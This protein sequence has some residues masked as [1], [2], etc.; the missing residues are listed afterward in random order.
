IKFISHLVDNKHAFERALTDFK[1]D[2]ILAD[3]RLPNFNGLEAIQ[4]LRQRASAPPLIIVSG[5]IGDDTAVDAIRTGAADY[6]LKERLTRLPIAVKRAL[7][8]AE[9]RR[10]REQAERALQESEER[11]RTIF[12]NSGTAVSIIEE[13]GTISLV[14]Q[15][16]VRMTG[17]S[18]TEVQGKK[19]FD[20]F[21]PSKDIQTIWDIHRLRRTK[22]EAAPKQYEIRVLDREG[23]IL[24]AIINA[25]LLP[26]T[27]KSLASIIDITEYRE[28]Q[29]RLL[30]YEHLDKFKSDL[31]NL[32]SHE[33][34]SPLGTIK[35]YVTTLLDYEER[36]EP[37]E[38]RE[39]LTSI[40][41]ATDRLT[42]LVDHLLDMS[43]LEA[44]L[45]KLK[46]E[47]MDICAL[48]EMAV[49][50]A[51][52]RAA[53]HSI[54][55]TPL[56][57]LPHLRADPKRVRQVLDN[58]IDN[59][60]KYSN[61]GTT[62]TIETKARGEEVFISVA[63]QGVGIPEEELPKVF[64]RAYRAKHR[65]SPG[66]S[67]LGFGLGLCKGLVEAHGGRIWLESELGKGTTAFFTLPVKAADKNAGSG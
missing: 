67:G 62:V 11:Y 49:N 58:L 3:Y 15:E 18:D 31:L 28:T 25:A 22:P 61:P 39:H 14:N 46:P 21:L 27:K 47:E 64:D 55:L 53:R 63:D 36:L 29:R 38:K 23:H 35:G 24:N 56:S 19:K 10:K 65:L 1:P 45:L 60:V 34:R 2:L 51:R 44:G 37:R 33:L 48:V 30:E 50:E 52:L 26:G 43:R 40:D 32:V 20:E 66:A 57:S 4:I 5:S 16:W 12:E 7:A 13:D 59:A 54:V 9:E 6:V 8:E 42:E 41:K 17:W